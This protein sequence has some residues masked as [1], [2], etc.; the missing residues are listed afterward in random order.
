MRLQYINT[1][2]ILKVNSAFMGIFSIYLVLF[3]TCV[4]N[5]IARKAAKSLRKTFKF[6]SLR[7]KFIVS[8][9]AI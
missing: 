5:I 1:V 9:S 3:G 8:I 7:H 4:E 2:C 6:F